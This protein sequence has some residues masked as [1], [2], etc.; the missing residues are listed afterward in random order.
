MGSE[1]S[2]S[3]YCLRRGTAGTEI[4][5]V[6]GWEVKYHHHYTVSGEVLLG[7]RSQGWE[8]GK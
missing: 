2:P 8:D 7:P 1:I 3:L 6:G 4:P 5:G